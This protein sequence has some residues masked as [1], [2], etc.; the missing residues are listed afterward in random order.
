MKV[1][2]V[3]PEAILYKGDVTSLS[4][5]GV[6]GEF[7]ML[8]DHAAIISVL[9]KGNIKL[10][11]AIQPKESVASRFIKGDK[12]NEF[13]LSI[14]GGTLEFNNNKATILAD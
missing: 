8:N 14:D 1:E 3:T 7:Q 12:P 13:L 9:T 6:N 5:P 10:Y 2:I 11:G 4:V